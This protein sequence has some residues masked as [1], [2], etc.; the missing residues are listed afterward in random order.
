MSHALKKFNH[1]L[2]ELRGFICDR[3]TLLL[4]KIDIWQNDELNNMNTSQKC[5]CILL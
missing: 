2:A 5:E 4:L 1:S 3:L